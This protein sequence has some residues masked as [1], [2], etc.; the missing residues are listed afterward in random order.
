MSAVSYDLFWKTLSR[1]TLRENFPLLLRRLG[2]QV[3]DSSYAAQFN[4]KFL[5]VVNTNYALNLMQQT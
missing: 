3:T 5:D 2:Y 4:F 1:Q